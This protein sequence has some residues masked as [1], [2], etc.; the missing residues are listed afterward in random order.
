MQTYTAL[1]PPVFLA[2][3]TQ[4][5]GSRTSPTRVKMEIG[6][7]TVGGAV[8][9]GNMIAPLQIYSNQAAGTSLN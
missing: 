7:A 2:A 6:S 3:L 4:A 8:G 5:D 1:K 9:R